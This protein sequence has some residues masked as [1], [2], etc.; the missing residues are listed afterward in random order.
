MKKILG[1]LLE[2]A[3]MWFEFAVGWVPGR[4]GK[5][6]RGFIYP[7]L[8]ESGWHLQVEE[9][10]KIRGPRNLRLGTSVG[11]GKDTWI[12]SRGGVVIGN[13][14]MIAPGVRIIS[15]G[16]RMERLDVPMIQQ[17]LYSKPIH[18]GNDVWIGADVIV[19]PGVTV[20]EG[21]IIAAASVV[22][23]DVPPMS[24]VAGSPARVVKS[25]KPA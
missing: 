23:K 8:I 5:F 19:L 24:V 9:G 14:V 13:N 11:L 16:H 22:T 7:L 20:G 1:Y 3:W 10:V 17:G 21:S 2:E 18:I 4:V 25:R 6:S 15:N 12:N